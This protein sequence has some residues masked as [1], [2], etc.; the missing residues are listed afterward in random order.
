M[1][2]TIS[3]A[4]FWISREDGLEPL[5]ELAA[6]LRAR[7]QRA[8]VER[9]DALALQALGHVARDDALREPLDDRG[10]ADAGLAD[11][12]RV[13]L[14]PA[15]EDLDDAADLLVA[16]D[17]RI[18]LAGLRERGQVAPVLLERLV[19]ALG[20]LRRDLLPAAHVLQRLEQRVARDDLEREQEVLDR[21][22]LVS[23]RAHLVER[24]VEHA[25]E[26]GRRL[27]LRVAAR[28]RRLLR[29]ARLGLGAKLG[30]SGA[31][32]IDERSRQLLVEERDREVVRASARG[33]PSRRASSCAPATASWLFRSAC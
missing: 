30:G 27:R 32:A 29:E 24:A 18:E 17:D 5:L 14:R 26:A 22:E 9:P 16:A 8:D 28:D 19:R 1:K 2:R 6:V 11:Q 31:G 15:R 10:L 12:H 21:D 3:P 25:A 7:E 33:C 20:I 23:E 4:A 13:V